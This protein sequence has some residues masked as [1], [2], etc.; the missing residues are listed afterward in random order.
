M[1]TYMRCVL[2]CVLAMS[3]SLP[4]R[5][6][7]PQSPPLPPGCQTDAVPTSD[8]QYPAQLILICLHRD[9]WN[10]Q[11][12]VYAHGYEAPQ[13]PLALPLDELTLPD[14]N[15]QPVFTPAVLLAR[16]FAFAT[17]SYRKNG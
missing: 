12:V 4:A 7:A 2:A 10:G 9:S 11:L 13:A 5:A 3:V 14:G 16:G 15:G 6:Q 1:P 8:P 17:T